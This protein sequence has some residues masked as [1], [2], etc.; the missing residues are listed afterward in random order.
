MKKRVVADVMPWREMARA[1]GG[2]LARTSGSY[3]LVVTVVS[4]FPWL[5]SCVTPHYP[6]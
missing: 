3:F 2:R 6:G 1:Y 4:K 5:N